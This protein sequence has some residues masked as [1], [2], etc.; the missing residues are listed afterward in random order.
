M[1]E[2]GG[3]GA[4][5]VEGGELKRERSERRMQVFFLSLCASYFLLILLTAL[6]HDELDIDG[7]KRRPEVD[8]ARWLARGGG[9]G[10]REE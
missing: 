7:L 4:V 1:V 9:R 8:D 5:E 6:E 3:G 2:G 10:H